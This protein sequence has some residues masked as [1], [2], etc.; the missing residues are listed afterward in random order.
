M[1]IKVTRIKNRFH[2]RLFISGKVLDEMA[3]QLK[4]DIGWICREMLRWADKTG[5][6]NKW[7][8]AARMRQQGSHLGR[9]W[10]KNKLYR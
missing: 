3:C 4:Q 5:F 1:E 2:A 7:T 6:G 9:V 8:N 10:Y